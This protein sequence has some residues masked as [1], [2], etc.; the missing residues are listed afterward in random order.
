MWT[1]NLKNA[2]LKF[3]TKSLLRE[4]LELLNKLS[5]GG[6]IDQNL[7][8]KWQPIADNVGLIAL[9]NP[10]NHYILVAKASPYGDIVSVAELLW[11]KAKANQQKIVMYIQSSKYFYLF[12]PLKIGDIQ[13]NQ[14]GLTKMVNF[15]IKNGINLIKLKESQDSLAKAVVKS[16]VYRDKLTK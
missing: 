4:A 13:L 3:G 15:S 7:S 12:D 5:K 16:E 14:R 10:A 2:K 8:G 1:T 11:R 6:L 9:E